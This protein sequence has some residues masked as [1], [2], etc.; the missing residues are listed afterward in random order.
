MPRFPANRRYYVAGGNGKLSRMRLLLYNIRYAMGMGT[1]PGMP[2]PGAGYLFGNRANFDEI[3]GFIKSQ[4]PDVVG[5]VEVDIGSMR[6][7]RINQAEA[8]ARALGH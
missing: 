4:T 8:I 7:G 6:S 2:V 1:S 5:L 3:T